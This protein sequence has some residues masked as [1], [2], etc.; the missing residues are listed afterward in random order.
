MSNIL[1]ILAI[2]IL[3]RSIYHISARSFYA[4]QDTKTPLYISV[5]AVGFNILLALYLSMKANMGVYGLAWAASIAAFLE[6]MILFVIMS[7]QISGLFGRSF[8]RPPPALSRR[9]RTCR[10]AYRR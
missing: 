3:F 8:W 5:F 10:P 6:V 1:G 4:R 9:C 2:A 7:R